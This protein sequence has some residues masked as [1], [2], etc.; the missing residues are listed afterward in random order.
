MEA[1][2]GIIW[3]GF[4]LEASLGVFS[5]VCFGS[6]LGHNLKGIC[7][8]S[9]LRFALEVSLGVFSEVRFG[10]QL[11]HNLEGICFGSELGC[12]F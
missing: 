8:E 1:S 9:E 10:S 12:I 11:G 4:A 2:L 7:F 6:Q 3:K 5:E